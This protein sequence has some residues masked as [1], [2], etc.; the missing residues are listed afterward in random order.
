MSA[1]QF[2]M[3]CLTSSTWKRRCTFIHQRTEQFRA[4]NIRKLFSN[5]FIS[6]QQ[7]VAATHTSY[8]KSHFCRKKENWHQ[9]IAFLI[10]LVPLPTETVL[11]LVP[12]LVRP[13]KQFISYVPQKAAG[14]TDHRVVQEMNKSLRSKAPCPGSKQ[15]CSASLQMLNSLTTVLGNAKTDVTKGDLGTAESLP[16]TRDAGFGGSNCNG[17]IFPNSC[18]IKILSTLFRIQSSVIVQ[19]EDQTI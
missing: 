19:Q 7:P 13:S 11:V 17:L 2:L 6:C 15:T 18:L 9:I 3:L 8:A 10:L 14:V 4:H 16:H 12:D 1:L 5:H